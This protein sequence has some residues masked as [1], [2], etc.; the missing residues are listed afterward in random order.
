MMAKILITGALGFVYSNFI[1]FAIHEKQP[2]TFVTI[3]KASND[4]F[5]SNI[6]VNKSLTNSYIADISDSHIIDTIF[7]H[8]KPDYVIHGAA[9]SSVD[10]AIKDPHI[11]L[12]SNVIG[13]QNIIDACLKYNV[14][15]LIFQSTDE[16]Y[17]AL[18]SEND[19]AWTETSPL[20]PRNYYSVSKASS[21]MLVQSAGN[22]FGLN[23]VI[24][25]SSNMYG[26]RQTHNK[27]IP[28]VIKCILENQK[29]PV[30]G[31]GDQIRSWLHTYD[32]YKAIMLLL[33]KGENKGIYNIDAHQE[34]SNIEVIHMICNYFNKGFDLIQ[35]VPDRLGH[36]FRYS[37]NTSKIE[38]LGWKPQ[39]KFKSD[40][41][42]KSV[43]EWFE[44]NQWYLK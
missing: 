33:E 16:V 21:D 13:T 24:A 6:Y 37:M 12:K 23:Y 41:G 27:L 4:R 28:R 2:H 22:T 30:Y 36:D 14:N 15:K 11:F 35:G 8:E 20:Q 17:G 10:E 34:F 7:K 18:S 43:C 3:D 19:K 39:I 42:L 26:N 1:R 40:D 25:R 32:N 29:I 44:K 38:E 9:E 31:K 5:L